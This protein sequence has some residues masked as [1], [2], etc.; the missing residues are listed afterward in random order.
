MPNAGSIIRTS[1]VRRAIAFQTIVANSADI[2]TTESVV[3]TESN[4]TFEDGRAYEFELKT[5]ISGSTTAT[6]PRVKIRKTN[7]S[8]TIYVDWFDCPHPNAANQNQAFDQ[9]RYLVRS[10]GSDLTTD[11]VVTLDENGG[12]GTCRLAANSAE[13]CGT[14][15]IWDVGASSDYPG[16]NT[17]T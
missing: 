5:L 13:A 1:D 12:G 8:G 6:R 15:T 10:A 4:V 7:A 9:S 3:L 14:F 2:G 11:V 16:V 17:I